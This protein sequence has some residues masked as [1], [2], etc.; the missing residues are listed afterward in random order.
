MD[1][2]ALDGRIREGEGLRLQ[3]LASRVPEDLA[4]VELGSYRGKST[5]YLASEAKAHVYAVDLWNLGGQRG[6]DRRLWSNETWKLFRQQTKPYRDKITP[7]RSRT[8]DAA[9][10]WD[11]PIGLLWIDADHSYEAC[12]AD[13]EAWS[14]FVV[15]GGVIAFHDYAPQWPGVPRTI[16]N[17]VIPSGLWTDHTVVDRVWSGVRV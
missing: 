3:F 11:K 6:K 2:A 10:D 7:I 4:I 12:L 1:L 8:V 17:H 16:D 13:Y 9:F 5:C 15:H 14:P